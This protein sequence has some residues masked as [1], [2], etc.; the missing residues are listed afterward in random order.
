MLIEQQNTESRN[1]CDR[2]YKCF[3]ELLR[4]YIPCSIFNISPD[5]QLFID[6]SRIWIK[7]D[8][9]SRRKD[10]PQD[11]QPFVFSN[12]F[13]IKALIYINKSYIYGKI[14]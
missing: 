12:I 10:P 14:R 1:W 6:K 11:Q 8:Y 3:P 7:E 5:E 2:I 4:F 9:V 13:M